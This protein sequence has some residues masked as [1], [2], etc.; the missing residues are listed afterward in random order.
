[1]KFQDLV[2]ERPV[3]DEIN[4]AINAQLMFF[5][6]AK[7]AP[8]QE[9]VITEINKIFN[10]IDTMR[11]LVSIRHTMDTRDSFYEEEQDF[12]DNFSPKV[13]EWQNKYYKS[14]C[15]SRFRKE[16]EKTYGKHLFKLAEMSLEA[17]SPEIM[18]DLAEEN[19]LTSR[20]A[21]LLASA[22]INFDDKIL[23]LAQIDPYTQSPDRVVR[24][25]AVEA[26]FNFFQGNE[27][28][29]DEI[30]SALVTVRDRMAKKLG[31]K[32]FVAL[33]YKR[34]LRTDYG[35]AEVEQFR[36]Q[37]KRD[38]VPITKKLRKRQSKRLGLK[39]LA[40]HDEGISFLTGN[41]IPQGNS[42][43]ILE[44]GKKMY[45]ELSP[46][47]SEFFKVM[48]EQNLLDLVA[49]EGK[50]GGGYCDFLPDHKVPFI[51]SNFNGTAGDIEV[52]THEAGHAFQAFRS[53][54]LPVPE[55]YFPTMESAEI[56]SMSMEFLTWPWMKLFFGP[57]TEKFK[58]NHL[59]EALLFIPYGVT[60]DAFQHWVYEN[61]EATPTERKAQWHALEKIYL[62]ARNYDGIDY[63]ER[64]G[65]WM[66]QAHIFEAPFYYIDYTLAQ[67]CAL[68]FWDAAQKDS[69]N[70]WKRYLALCDLGGSKPFTDLVKSA[71]LN[72]PFEE[73]SLA[74][75]IP[76]IQDYLSQ[77]NDSKL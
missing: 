23:N 77:V 49:R 62:P 53:R 18:D 42:E 60:V 61:P 69:T 73:G 48:T 41:A 14:L 38:L 46:E 56:H 26:K 65:F 22:Q 15:T 2:Y 29:L 10:Q 12:F 51:F 9:V 30:F 20:Y 8:T 54:N 33:G 44:N 59:T 76:T 74:A 45:D 28:E 47:T 7:N 63:L 70:A 24:K 50:S 31:Y 35:A 57:Q 11:A 72:N 58:F 75:I 21:K 13:S 55:Y 43:W 34:M 6:L 25:S 68:Q 1:M 16:L 52:L 5:K 37:V 17:F 19:T 71:G 67:T 39:T 32:N 64:G 3:A 4:N 40:F 27:T 36:N 66:R